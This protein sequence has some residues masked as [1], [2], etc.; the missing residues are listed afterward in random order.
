M[1]C[2]CPVHFSRRRLLGGF[3]GLALLAGCSENPEL[4]RRQLVLASDEQLA[5]LAEA[6]WGDMRKTMAPAADPRMQ[7]RLQR[8]GGAIA[9]ATGRDDLAWEFV[10]FDSPDI[11]AFVLPNGKVAALRGL[12]ELAGDDDEVGSVIGHEAGHVLARHAAERVSQQVAVQAGVS[13]A[14]IL[15]SENLGD[16]AGQ[17]AAALGMGAVYGVLLPYSRKHELE[18]DRIGVNLAQ[19][20]GLDPAG[21]VRFFERMEAAGAG[22]PKPPEV[23]STHPADATRLAALRE[24]VATIT[25]AG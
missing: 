3:G 20:A 22:K 12:M 15:L 5:E 19:Q 14:E 8:I 7:A 10:V 6:G 1:A 24:A 18:A 9:R 2:A 16:N 25:A 21:A 11:N 4:G 23:L 13:L 17:V